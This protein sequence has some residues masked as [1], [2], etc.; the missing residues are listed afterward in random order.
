MTVSKHNIIITTRICI[1][2]LCYSGTGSR[3]WKTH[4]TIISFYFQFNFKG[5]TEVRSNRNLGMSSDAGT[6]PDT[7]RIQ[8][9]NTEMRANPSGTVF[10]PR[11]Y[12]DQLPVCGEWSTGISDTRS[13]KS[14]CKCTKCFSI[15]K[16]LQRTSM[17]STTIIIRNS[18]CAN[19]LQVR[20]MWKS[21]LKIE[22]Y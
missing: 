22:K 21:A 14:S 18:I 1:V 2:N 4:F 3:E 19:V 17:T 20:G 11:H 6:T 15:N 5:N 8:S 13:Y 16:R 10:T 9:K 7:S 12:A